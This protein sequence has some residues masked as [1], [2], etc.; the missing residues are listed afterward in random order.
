MLSYECAADASPTREHRWIRGPRT[1]LPPSADH[2]GTPGEPC[3]GGAERREA[4]DDMSSGEPGGRALDIP[5]GLVS[6]YF[7]TT[8]NGEKAIVG[9]C[10]VLVSAREISTMR[11][12][13]PIMEQAARAQVRLVIIALRVSGEALSTLVTNRRSGILDS[14]VVVQK[15]RITSPR[16]WREVATHTGS[17]IFGDEAGLMLESAGL[18]ELGRA[19]RV[20]ATE[21]ETKIYIHGRATEQYG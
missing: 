16:F 18:D 11:Q 3:G 7:A 1:G 19:M 15:G 9:D 5:F 13:L 14:C 20:E 2:A 10:R 17:A 12:L 8:N 6:H 21:H 4:G